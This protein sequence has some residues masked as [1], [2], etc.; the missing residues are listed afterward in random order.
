MPFERLRRSLVPA[1][2]P[3]LMVAMAGAS[4]ARGQNLDELRAA[5]DAARRQ[6]ERQARELDEQRRR[7]QAQEN[8]LEALRRQLAGRP[9]PAAPPATATPPARAVAPP[10]PAVAAVAPTGP[11]GRQAEAET[12]QRR[13]DQRV[14]DTDPGL[15]RSGGVLL[16]RGA[17]S[18]EP[19]L[20]YSYSSVNR[21]IVS[22]FTIIPGITFGSVDIREVQRRTLTAGFT[23]RIGLADGL[24]A[25]VRLPF[26][27]RSDTLQTQPSDINASPITIGPTGYGLGDVEF[28][29]SYQFTTGSGSWPILVGNLRV[30]TNTGRSPFDVPIYTIDDQPNGQFLRGLERELPTG[31]GFWGIEPGVT[32]IVPTDPAV[33]F[34]S[35]RYIWNLENTVRIRNSSGG[36][37]SRAR[38]DPGDGIGINLGI[39]FALNERVSL[40]L[41]Y[42]HV[43]VFTSR[44]NGRRVA[45][46]S[47]DIGTFNIGLSYRLSEAMSLNVGVGIGVTDGAPDARVLVR[48]PYRLSLF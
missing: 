42:E 44:S 34:A 7:L 45:G 33:L 29:A 35:V 43:H 15:A 14:L 39:G 30:K 25:N 16:P 19:S 9:A 32:M 2:L 10:Q 1:S 22:G 4:P 36:P 5:I 31:T 8:A 41:G 27:Y 26:I 17:L 24:E 3:V 20:D 12:A 13:A 21:A 37:D 46:S 38:I 48:V 47:Y 6:I 11:V 40:S 23:M 28:G 18:L